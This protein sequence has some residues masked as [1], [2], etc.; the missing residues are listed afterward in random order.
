MSGPPQSLSDRDLPGDHR[1]LIARLR[2]IS[3]LAVA[4]FVSTF[5]VID[6]GLI[7]V[8][9]DPVVRLAVRWLMIGAAC[10]TITMVLSRRT[11]RTVLDSVR[12]ERAARS[13]AE[14]L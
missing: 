8:I 1:V 2:T 5:A 10:L 3:W 7:A 11:I 4:G 13:E 14:A 12:R 6:L 9:H